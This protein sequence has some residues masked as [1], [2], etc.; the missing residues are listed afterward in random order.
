MALDSTVLSGDSSANAPIADPSP[1]SSWE[2]GANNSPT[3]TLVDVTPPTAPDINGTPSGVDPTTPIGNGQAAGPIAPPAPSAPGQKPSLWKTVLQGAL[4][5]LANSGGATHFG[6]GLGAGAAGVFKGQQQEVENQQR[7]QMLQFESL[8]A[9]DSHIAALDTHRAMNQQSAEWKVQYAQKQAEY[10]A[11]LQNNFGI[12][13]NLSFNDSATEANAGLQTL[14]NQNGGTIPPVVTSQ[15]PADHGTPGSIAVYSPSQQQM[16]QNAAGFRNLINIQRQVLG[17]PPIDDPSFNSLGFKGQRDAAQAAISF[18]SP[19]PGYNLDKNKPD[20]LPNVLAQKQQQLQQYQAHKDVN[21][22]PDADPNVV[23]Q[24]QNGISYL[25]SSWDTSNKME[26]DAQAANIRA[27]APAK[28]D[29]ARQEDLAKQDT[30]QGRATLAKTQQDLIDAKYKNAD[31]HQKALFDTGVDPQT[32]ER[33]NLANAPDEALID[34]NTKQPIPTKMLATLKPTQQESNRADF[35]RSALH[36]LDLID[37]LKAKGKLPNGPLSGMTTK[38]LIK[39]GLSDKDA[40][41]AYGL[42]ALAQ[43]AA[44]GAHVGGR[45]SSEIMQ[46]MNGLLSLNANDAQFE[47]QELAL[48]QVMTP[49]AQQGG[50]QTV[51]QYKQEVIGSIQTLK[52]G[53]KV[54]VT[55]LDKNGNFVGSP[56]Q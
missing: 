50:R 29:A 24:L 9:A 43:S 39:S 37:E 42:I 16:R 15:Q 32:G 23:R 19:T 3:P 52:N 6:S 22:N 28:A 8:R 56:V 27:T 30:P 5:G 46:K 51:A 53:Q 54:K 12:E 49:Y 1:S 10:Q 45:F 34:G 14:A 2:A 4:W 13:P 11:F 17:Q 55:G 35:A 44:T 47:G 18:L 26:N 40:A 7:Q 20:Y 41:D 36:S 48:R 33:L 38:A 25:Q 31:A 21:G